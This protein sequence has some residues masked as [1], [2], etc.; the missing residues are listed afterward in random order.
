MVVAEVTDPNGSGPGFYSTYFSPADAFDTTLPW[1][2]ITLTKGEIEALIQ[3]APEQL[4]RIFDMGQGSTDIESVSLEYSEVAVIRPWYKP[5]FF[6]SRYWKLPDN[7][8]ISDGNVPRK[9]SVPAY[10]TSMIV[11][12][13]VKVAR[14]RPPAAGAQTLPLVFPLL[15]NVALQPL[16][17]QLVATQVIRPQNIALPAIALNRIEPIRVSG[18]LVDRDARAEPAQKMA[19]KPTTIKSLSFLISKKTQ[20]DLKE[21]AIINPPNANERR[22]YLKAKF[23]GTTINTTIKKRKFIAIRQKKDLAALQGYSFIKSK[24]NGM[25]LDV[26]G[27]NSTEGTP[28]IMWSRKDSGIENQLWAFESGPEGYFFIKSKLNGMVLDVQGANST[29]GTPTIMWSR[30]DSGIENQLWALESELVTENY[31]FDGVVVLAFVCKRVPLSPNPDN[32]LQWS[33]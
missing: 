28:T 1:I 26:Q 25:V 31:S 23:R 13:N 9:G 21:R 15:S 27:A 17:H 24:L 3:D 33:E 5:E 8:V 22:S 7:R 4:K 11:V 20:I 12:R 10:I 19:H 2:T 18:L 32:S 14:S 29:E 6:T 16:R 30:K